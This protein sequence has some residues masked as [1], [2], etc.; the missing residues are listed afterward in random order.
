MQPMQVQPMQMQTRQLQGQGQVNNETSCL[1]D[2]NRQGPITTDCDAMV[3]NLSID[4]L[5]L[6]PN[7][8]KLQIIFFSYFSVKYQFWS[9][10]PVLSSRIACQAEV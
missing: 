10:I 9:Y 7:K 4:V 5:T 6:Y 8:H 2:A 1:Y 3:Q